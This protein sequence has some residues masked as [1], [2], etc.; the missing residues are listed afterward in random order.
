MK[1]IPIYKILPVI[2]LMLSVLVVPSCKLDYEP[3]GLIDDARLASDTNMVQ[4]IANGYNYLFKKPIDFKGTVNQNYSFLRQYFFMSEFES[5]NV[6]CG[7]TTT[8]P[9]MYSFLL[10]FF[11][12][13]ENSSYFYFNNYKMINSA[14]VVIDLYKQN[15][16]PINTRLQRQLIG[17]N[18]FMRAFCHFTLV[19]YFAHPYSTDGGASDG[20]ILRLSNTDPTDKP[21]SKVSEVYQAVISDLKIASTLLDSTTF[22]TRG[23]GYPSIYAANAMLSRVYLYMENWD[24]ATYYAS[25]V[26][27]SGVFEVTNDYPDYFS[28]AQDSKETI[29]CIYM[30]P[31]DDLLK[32][33]SIASM[34]YSTPAGSG[35]GEEYASDDLRVL[36]EKDMADVRNSYIVPNVVNGQIQVKQGTGIRIYYVS[37]F[38]N[39]DGSPT[40]SS[41]VLFRISEMYLNRAEAYAQLGKT[42]DALN[43]L[44]KIRVNRNAKLFNGGLP[45]GYADIKNVVADERRME[46]CFEGHRNFDIFRNKVDMTRDYWGYHLT[47]LTESQVDYTQKP[48]EVN[49]AAWTN[50]INIKWNEY[51]Y[52]YVQPIY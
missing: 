8:D 14:N 23:N 2:A 5:D 45:A 3:Q 35:W 22:S 6:T 12:S 44:D 11:S 43:D 49:S 39:Q 1:N 4:L 46:L 42:E 7:Q 41:P 29:W 10:N 32:F 47:G 34:Y 36:L 37:K 25:K 48:S 19:K 52:V 21:S 15:K 30:S 50:D 31:A 17:E 18:Y 40:L 13:Q 24:S 20:I 16:I 27:N 51:R 38:S 9:F 26:I 28:N 33:G